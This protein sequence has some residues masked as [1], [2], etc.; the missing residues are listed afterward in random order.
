MSGYVLVYTTCYALLLGLF[1]C[2]KANLLTT[3]A[4]LNNGFNAFKSAATNKEDV[5]GVDLNKL[6]IRMLSAALGRNV[7]CCTLEDLK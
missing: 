7:G 6:L 3:L 4:I 1:F 2:I 5:L